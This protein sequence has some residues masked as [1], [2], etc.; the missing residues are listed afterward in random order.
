M[1]KKSQKIFGHETKRKTSKRKMKISGAGG[2]SHGRND[3]ESKF[4]RNSFGMR[5]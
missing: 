5:D 3:V 1:P 4:R 2:M